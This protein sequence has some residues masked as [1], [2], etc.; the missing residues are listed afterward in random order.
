MPRFDD[1]STGIEQN[2]SELRILDFW[3]REGVFARLQAAR[4]GA[5][6][7]VFY[8]GPP[9][10]NGRPGVHHAMA[11]SIK[12]VVCR[13]RSMRGCLVERKGGWDTHG[14]PVEIE[15]EKQLGLKSKPE[16]EKFGV[17]EFNRRC[18]ESVQKYEADW[19]E[20]TRRMGYWLDMDH[21]Y[22]T[23]DNSYIE[24][25]WWILKR[26]WDEGLIYEG[27]KILP[28]CPRCGT[29][30]SSHEVAQGYQDVEDPSVWVRF[31]LA[32]EPEVSLLVWTTTPWTLPSN[33]AVA[34]GEFAEYVEVEFGGERLILARDRLAALGTEPPKPGAPGGG[35]PRELRSFKG[36]ELAGRRYRP[37]FDFFEGQAEKVAAY[38][39]PAGEPAEASKLYRVAVADFVS[40]D[41]GTGLVHIAPAFGED[42]YELGR[43]EQLPVLQPVDGTGCFTADV[44]PW[45]GQFVK[46]ADKGLTRD[47]KERGLL[48]RQATV[49]HS[50]PHCWRCKSPLLYYARRSWYI[51][52]TRI[53][54]RL[55]KAHDQVE[56]HPRDVGESR[57]A[58]WVANNIDWALSRDRYWGTPLPVWRCACGH[59]ECVGGVEELRTRGV[60]LPAE[61]DLHKPQVDGYEYPCPK[62]K[63]VMRRVPEVIDVWFDSGAMPFAQR[64]YPFENRELFQAT[65]PA[66]FISEGID[67]SR[68]WFYSLLVIGAFLEDGPAFRNVVPVEMILDKQGQRMHKSRGNAVDP[69]EMMAKEGADALRWYLFTASPTWLPTRFD[70]AGVTEV[71][72]R[73]F[74]TL[75]NTA[76]FFA[77]YANL[78]DLAPGRPDPAKL[79]DLDRWVLA[80]LRETRAEVIRGLDNYEITP[81]ARALQR[82][83][84]DDV[85]NW[86]VR[87]SR[88]R[89]WKTAE[90]A[91]HRAAFDTL[92]HVLVEVAKLLAPFAPFAAEELY[93]KLARPAGAKQV[94]VHLETL[95]GPADLDAF[96]AEFA[97]EELLRQMGAVQAIVSLARAAREQASLKVRQPL[98]RLVVVPPGAAWLADAGMRRWEPVIRDEVNVKAIA[99]QGESLGGRVAKPN[100]RTLGK[101][102]GKQMNAVAGLIREAHAHGERRTW[103]DA[104]AA[105]GSV[106]VAVDGVEADVDAADVDLQELQPEGLAVAAGGGWSV[107]VDTRLTPALEQEGIFRELV[108]LVQNLRKSAGLEVSDR[109]ELGV[110]AGPRVAAAALAHSEAVKSEV[111]AVELVFGPVAG[112]AVET[113]NLVG[114]DVRLTLRRA[115]S[116]AGAQDATRAL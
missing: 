37:L 44:G 50:Y 5:P 112:G 32:D 43:R 70:R 97:A 41:D 76:Q 46:A 103:L 49:H 2:E 109:I 100:F 31:R 105:G 23:F 21:P 52:T 89:F 9:T 35:E 79:S 80:A 47:L 116:S 114:E 18:R 96:E 8:E 68:G 101:K 11:R 56:W 39:T 87:R 10:A 40:M 90:A 3:E 83:V 20:L 86:Y 29:P 59:A 16:I 106:R 63:G 33:T 93:Q 1:F 24:T 4:E 113:S 91:D 34:V 64:H 107:G 30:L 111:L 36:S 95:P 84:M 22:R 28:Y 71:S 73:F 55:V 61:L 12:D 81:A 7:F 78:E 27:H 99:W 48:F 62:C 74:A 25:V 13:Y 14:L 82:F 98:A 69:F 42:D 108:H 45:A 26:F 75:R 53:R 57:F 88:R 67:Q 92:H 104:W 60:K 54:E 15:V 58:N 102:F 94:S 110:E 115:E 17:A 77:L 85:S 19:Q 6:R 66:D 38:T 51:A 72:R 65:F